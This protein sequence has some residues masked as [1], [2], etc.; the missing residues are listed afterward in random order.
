MQ[1]K[2]DKSNFRAL[3]AAELKEVNGGLRVDI[4]GMLPKLVEKIIDFLLY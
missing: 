3:D 4:P 2:T 1:T